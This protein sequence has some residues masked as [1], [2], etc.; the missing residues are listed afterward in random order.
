MRQ[1]VVVGGGIA[2]LAAAIA[3]A[4]ARWKVAVHEQ[5]TAIEPLGAALSLWPNATAALDQLGILA[6]VEASGAP[7]RSM[8]VADRGGRPIIGPRQVRG[9]ALM[10]TRSALQDCLI[11]AL[12]PTPL[13]LGSTVAGVEQDR[14]GALVRFVGGRT[15]VA[16]LVIDAGGIWSTIVGVP[17][18]KRPEFSRYGGVVA[19]SDPVDGP[20][21]DG[22]A[23]EFWGSGERFGVFELP[24]RCRYWFY[25]Q[26]QRNG[27]AA[28]DHAYIAG[29]VSEWVPAVAEAVAATAPDRLIPFVIHAKPV[30][31]ELGRG[32]IISVGDAAHAMEPNLGQGACQALEDAAAFGGGRPRH[33]SRP[34]TSCFR[35]ASPQAGSSDRAAIGRGQ[36]RRARTRAGS[37]GDACGPS[38]VAGVRDR[39]GGGSCPYHARL[40]VR[41]IGRGSTTVGP[42]PRR[43]PLRT[44]SRTRRRTVHTKRA[45]PS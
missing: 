35:G 33:V 44:S 40:R 17:E 19:L 15:V 5:A 4:R 21:L 14:V 16:D 20:G 9:T 8:L 13:H 26:D 34:H 38:R 10:V 37:R 29:R 43:G 39:S 18:R 36:D 3:L 25:M 23:S 41:L 28:P 45:W 30:P 22:A 27:Q 42:K 1:A 6:P 31:K 7:L 2:G 12:G 24:E 32:R 11:D